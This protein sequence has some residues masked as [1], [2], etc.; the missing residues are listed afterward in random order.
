LGRGE[1]ITVNNHSG[2]QVVD[3][4]AFARDDMAEYLSMEHSRV[5]LCRLVPR[6]GDTL[7][8]NRRR[9]M[10]TWIADTT[11]GA[12]DTL[13]AACDLQRYRMLGAVGYHDNCTDNLHAA[14]ATLGLCSAHTPSPLNLFMNVPWRPDGGLE[15]GAPRCAPGQYVTLRAEQDLIVAF[16]ACPQDMNAINGGIS[17]DALYRMGPVS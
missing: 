16:S 8:S 14:I 3:T 6:V 5:A 17:R 10:L 12:H 7:V 11:D 1:C 2:T 4:W 13:M 15:F 9:A